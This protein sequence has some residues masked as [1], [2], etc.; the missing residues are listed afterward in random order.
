MKQQEDKRV[1]V[2]LKLTKNFRKAR[3]LLSARLREGGF[4]DC[5]VKMAGAVEEQRAR[6]ANLKGVKRI[7]AVSSCKGGVGKS[8]VAVNLAFALSKFHKMR[9]GIFDADIYG[10]SLPVLLQLGKDVTVETDE[11]G[12]NVQPFTYE[13]VKAM[14][15]GW[16][17]PGKRAVVRG[18]M[19]S[20][21]TAQLLLV[22]LEEHALG[23]A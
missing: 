12:R 3:E 15:F 13:G 21:I 5:E 18:P 14:S 8:T 20:S 19:V 10:P 17:A 7:I 1:I 11:S 9:V 16:V 23:R 2:S 6:G 4:A 22:G